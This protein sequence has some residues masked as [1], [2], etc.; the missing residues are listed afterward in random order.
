MVGHRR[1]GAHATD[2][3]MEMDAAGRCG[4]TWCD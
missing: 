4:R 3:M 1:H 2:W